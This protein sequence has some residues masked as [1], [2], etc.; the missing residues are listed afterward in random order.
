MRFIARDEIDA[1]QLESDELVDALRQAFQASSAGEIAMKPKSTIGQPD[2]AFQISTLAAWPKRNLGIFHS[3]LGAPP[4]NLAPGEAHYRSY[5]LV[6]N[7]ERG[8]VRALVDGSFTSTMLPAGITALAARTLA[9]ADS[10]TA[11]FVG[12][13]LQTRVNL[14]AL[15]GLFPLEE[16]RILGRS[17]ANAEA[18]AREIAASGLKASVTSDAESAISGAD[19]IVSTVPSGPRLVPFLDPSW[20]SPGAFVSAV[21][22]GRSWRDGFEAFDRIVSDDRA[23]AAVQHAEGRLRYGGSYDSELPELV[24]GQ[25]P[26]RQSAKERIV[27][28]H[29]G[30]IVG[31]MA[32]TELIL[33]RL[34]SPSVTA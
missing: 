12:A 9:R 2:G 32:I 26:P 23:Q 20:V 3:I 15:R 27:L 33:D 8:T 14:A 21:D 19:I 28:I 7:Y 4:A 5:Q 34:P 24:T 29:P 11:T 6:T 25:R 31:V 16:V 18:L 13:G 22:L 30:N 17:A 10:R 1:L